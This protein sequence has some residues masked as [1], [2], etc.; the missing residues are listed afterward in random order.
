MIILRM[1]I[2]SKNIIGS[3]IIFALWFIPI[4]LMNKYGDNW[5]ILFAPIVIASLAW[6]IFIIEGG[7]N[8][9]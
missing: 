5:E 3:I 9:D 2:M 1:M 8:D 7:F 6:L 4:Y